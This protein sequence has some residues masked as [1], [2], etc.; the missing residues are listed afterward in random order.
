MKRSNLV[1]ES[2]ALT[3]GSVYKPGDIADGVSAMFIMERRQQRG[4]RA[5]ESLAARAAAKPADG[6]RRA[7]TSIESE[8]RVTWTEGRRRTNIDE[9]P[10]IS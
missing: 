10:A 4:G 3:R 9:Y 7:W 2:C 8:R 5:V 1:R 6:G